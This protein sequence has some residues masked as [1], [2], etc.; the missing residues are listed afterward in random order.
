M[1]CNHIICTHNMKCCVRTVRTSL[2]LLNGC[3]MVLKTVSAKQ[4]SRI[5]Q[6][7]PSTNFN[8]DSGGQEWRVRDTRRRAEGT[9]RGQEK[10]WQEGDEG[11]GLEEVTGRATA[12]TVEEK[13][14]ERR[15]SKLRNSEEGMIT[16]YISLLEEVRS[17]PNQSHHT[18]SH[19]ITSH[20][21]WEIVVGQD[22]SRLRCQP[23]DRIFYRD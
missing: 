17:R 14:N 15:K 6:S 12:G 1:H 18:T 2:G 19:H 23:L 16:E 13:N 3:A 9:E 20:H 21:T 10:D 22:R 8:L 5:K 4:A 7:L 11:G